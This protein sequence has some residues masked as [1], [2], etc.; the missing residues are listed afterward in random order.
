VDLT[1]VIS[2]ELRCSK[3]A[4]QC[5]VVKGQ[6]SIDGHTLQMRWMNHWTEAQ[7]Q[8]RMLKCPAGERRIFGARLLRD[9]EQMTLGA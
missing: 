1:K 2:R 5:M 8:G 4:V 3:L 7:L 9:Y 6:V